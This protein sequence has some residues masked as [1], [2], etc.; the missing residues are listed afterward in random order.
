MHLG[1]TDKTR[2]TSHEA[3]APCRRLNVDIGGNLPLVSRTTA[4]RFTFTGGAAGLAVDVFD[5]EGALPTVTYVGDGVALA[6]PQR[7][8][9]SQQALRWSARGCGDEQMGIFRTGELLDPVGPRFDEGLRGR[10]FAIDLRFATTGSSEEQKAL[11]RVLR[12]LGAALVVE[13]VALEQAQ[14]RVALEPAVADTAGGYRRALPS[15]ATVLTSSF[16]AD[17]YAF[18]VLEGVSLATSTGS[19]PLR[20]GL[21]TLGFGSELIE[22]AALE[23]TLELDVERCDAAAEMGLG[24]TPCDAMDLAGVCLPVSLQ[25]LIGLPL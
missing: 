15:D 8:W 16:D 23:G 3:S 2:S 9:P 12:Q 18:F 19:L 20:E 4:L 25:G 5:D 1:E 14:L 13:I 10:R 22:E 17:P 11:L 6:L 7:P 24:C 21:L